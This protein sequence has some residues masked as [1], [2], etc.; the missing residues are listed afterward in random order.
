M[1]LKNQITASDQALI[2]F[3]NLKKEILKHKNLLTLEIANLEA[4]STFLK[5]ITLAISA[6]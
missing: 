5:K 3:P 1:Q 6:H 4:Y 2:D